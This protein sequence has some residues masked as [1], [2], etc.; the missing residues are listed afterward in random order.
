MF[1]AN[2]LGPA[3]TPGGAMIMMRFIANKL[4]PDT[5]ASAEAMYAI[6][7]DFARIDGSRI[8]PEAAIEYMLRHRLIERTATGY[9][10]SAGASRAA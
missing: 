9:S 8:T 3:L 1:F 5:A 4:K 10:L 6:V 7:A 2:S